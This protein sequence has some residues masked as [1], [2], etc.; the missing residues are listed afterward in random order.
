MHNE[1]E[2]ADAADGYNQN[3]KDQEAQCESRDNSSASSLRN[4]HHHETDWCIGL[5]LSSQWRLHNRKHVD[6]R[7]QQFT[8]CHIPS[9]FCSFSIFLYFYHM[10]AQQSAQCNTDVVNLSICSSVCQ[11]LV[12]WQNNLANHQQS[13]QHGRLGL[14]F[15]TT[16][17]DKISSEG[18][19]TQEYSCTSENGNFWSV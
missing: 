13:T 3:H 11:M 4:R 6:S 15:P 14:I 2:E 8:M 10:L 7:L 5:L 19:Q 16:K 1:F 18:H 9:S 12:L 17:T